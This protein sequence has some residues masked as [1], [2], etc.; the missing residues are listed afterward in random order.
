LAVIQHP[1]LRNHLFVELIR[2]NLAVLFSDAEYWK[3]EGPVYPR[4]L[5]LLDGSR[6][7]SDLVDALRGC[8]NVAEVLAA[9]LILERSGYLAEAQTAH[10]ARSITS[11]HMPRI[12]E[13]L[14]LTTVP[15]G[16][17]TIAISDD[18]LRRDLAEFARA[19]ARD[20]RAWLPLKSVG[21]LIW[22]GPLIRPP[23]TPCWDCMLERVRANRP[24]HAWLESL[25][26]LRLC[27]TAAAP[28]G[29]RL[30]EV[31]VG[32]SPQLRKWF[33]QS[34]VYESRSTLMTI[35]PKTLQASKHVVL[36][37]PGCPLCVRLPR[38]GLSRSPISPIVLESRPAVESADGGWRTVSP[39]ETFNRHKHHISG[40]TGIVTRLWRQTTSSRR[41]E[42][43]RAEHLFAPPSEEP[44]S[45]GRRVS[46]GKGVSRGQARTS[47]LC[48]ALERYSGV[49]REDD[50][51]IRA[52]FGALGDAAIQPNAC[53]NYSDAQFDRRD[54]LNAD[55]SARGWVPPR[56]NP[57]QEI[58][59]T[60]V[61]SL[62]HESVR[63]VPTAYCYYGYCARPN[64]WFCRA[65]SN[66]CAAGN[67]IEEAILQAFLELVERDAVAIWWYNEI[68][69]PFVD[70][71]SFS[72]PYSQ[73]TITD[74][75]RAGHSLRVLDLTTDLGIPVFV[76][77]V[78]A[79][80]STRHRLLLGFGAHL[81]ADI[82]IARALTELN[83]WRCGVEL[84][85]AGS[86]F[87]D[88]REGVGEFLQRRPSL[89]VRGRNDFVKADYDDIRNAVRSC[90]DRAARLGLETLVLDQTREDIS[91][92][93]VR[94]I[95]PGLR[96]FWPRFGPGRLYDV[97]V[98]LDWIDVAR[99]ES[100]LNNVHI[101]I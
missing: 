38:R 4:L 39:Q 29:V 14:G 101:L 8:A 26:R 67:T 47:A 1:T 82:A 94:V 98:E 78:Q 30:L 88:E 61:W 60:P 49:F 58:D 90:V 24:V 3:F 44:F 53:A 6:S 28:L 63:Y 33:A 42:L 48:E 75:E 19:A 77:V 96:H 55:P 40:V 51:R 79:A 95:V 56:F 37:Q 68:E 50:G 93:V 12:L 85:D 34:K 80:G 71:A 92:P 15:G 35:D 89:A 99:T 9:L 36:R 43:Y 20:D 41:L 59:W 27:S 65:D 7:V 81:D 25:G 76:A 73:K 69:R 87:S 13:M 54:S 21:T 83:Q 22:V 11:D 62:T 2:P 32:G 57:A 97:A 10:S 70:L 31:S 5:P 46:A 74:C 52:S 23:L 45:T 91:L 86:S 16:E 17:L 66:G 72:N 100:Q 84:G 18:Y 64:E